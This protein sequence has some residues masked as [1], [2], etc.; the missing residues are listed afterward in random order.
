LTIPTENAH[1]GW[2]DGL[3]FNV[4]GARFKMVAVEGGK[5]VMGDPDSDSEY[6]KSHKVTLTGFCIGETE[7]TNLLYSRITNNSGTV[8][9]TDKAFY[10]LSHA[11]SLSKITELNKLLNTTFNLPT[12]AQWEF[13]AKG[14]TKSKGYVYS[15]SNNIDEV[16]WYNGNAKGIIQ[17]VKQM[18]PN[19]LGIYDMTG[20]VE[21]HVLDYYAPY[22]LSNQIDPVIKVPESTNSSKLHVVRGGTFSSSSVSCYNYSRDYLTSSASSYD[23]AGFRLALNWD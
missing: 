4:N 1:N 22:P 15:G 7:V 9:N 16:A 2:I 20:N 6:Y 18:K 12:E 3:H 11:S 14:G 21:E 17:K 5:F 19:E 23:Y 13:A 10:D 8:S